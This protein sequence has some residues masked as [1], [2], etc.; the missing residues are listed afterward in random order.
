MC[1]FFGLSTS[2]AKAGDIYEENFK[3]VES[4]HKMGG[5]AGAKAQN[6]ECIQ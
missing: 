5:I 3:G 2:H 6:F 4:Q 1:S